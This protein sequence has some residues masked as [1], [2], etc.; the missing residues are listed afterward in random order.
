MEHK[1]ALDT[2]CRI[3]GRQ[4]AWVWVKELRGVGGWGVGGMMRESRRRRGGRKLESREGLTISHCST[5]VFK[6]QHRVWLRHEGWES[7]VDRL[8]FS[9]SFF[10]I[11]F[12]F[13]TVILWFCQATDSSLLLLLESFETHENRNKPQSNAKNTLRKHK[14]LICVPWCPFYCFFLF[15]WK[16]N[17][18]LKFVGEKCKF[19]VFP[20]WSVYLSGKYCVSEFIFKNE[21]LL[22]SKYHLLNFVRAAE[23]KRH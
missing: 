23:D 11:F 5:G 9:L 21:H 2:I 18:L 20:G 14:D 12:F 15:I 8:S 6:Y 13:P 16:Y 10:S 4:L 17:V 22:Y 19:M 7:S 1:H 3:N